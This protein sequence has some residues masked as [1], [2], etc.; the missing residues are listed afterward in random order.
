MQFHNKKPIGFTEENPNQSQKGHMK[1][2]LKFLALICA[3]TF[4]A[5]LLSAC[6][7]PAPP[8][9]PPAPAPE[10]VHPNS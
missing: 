7:H 2:Y 6:D 10:P 1:S 8:P 9:P 5:A 4:S 3:L